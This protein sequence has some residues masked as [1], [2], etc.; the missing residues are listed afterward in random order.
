M[1]TIPTHL[2]PIP[3][4]C[5]KTSTLNPAVYAPKPSQHGTLEPQNS[6]IHAPKGLKVFVNI[7]WD[8]HVPQPPEGNEETIR[9]AMLGQDV[10]DVDPD[11]WYVPVVVS[12]GRQDTDKVGRPALVF[13]CIYHTSIKTRALTDPDFK[14]FIIELALQRLEVQ[15]SLT[16]S[17][18]IGTPNIASKGKLFPRTVSIPTSL[19]SKSPSGIS[20]KSQQPLIQELSSSPPTSPKR[21]VTK[22]KGILKSTS[23]SPFSPLAKDKPVWHWRMEGDWLKITI[24]VPHLTHNLIPY[25]TV[26]IEPRRLILHIPGRET[27][28]INL[29]LSDAEIIATSSTSATS[30]GMIDLNHGGIGS[31]PDNILALKRERDLKVAVA[32][33]EW[34]VAQGVLVIVA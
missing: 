25:T 16:L 27:L 19:F 12:D 28:D 10:D 13:D 26:D 6:P 4:F 23:S 33:A 8:S 9:R 30:L 15:T 2:K 14:I 1:S 11:A 20:P 34:H 3:G 21:S 24:S 5:I 32:M 7:A 18:Q 31:G 22:P 17:R 29:D